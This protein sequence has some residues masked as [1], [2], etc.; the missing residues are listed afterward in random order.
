MLYNKPSHPGSVL[1]FNFLNPNN[2]T[3]EQLS[4]ETEIPLSV[5][6][7]ILNEEQSVTDNIA[8]KF[9]EYFGTSVGYWTDI[10]ARYDMWIKCNIRSEEEIEK[11]NAIVAE[12]MDKYHSVFKLMKNT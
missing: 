2:I 8:E 5:I 3:P 10:Q 1:W 6:E 9:A 7:G 12:M 4:R 11:M